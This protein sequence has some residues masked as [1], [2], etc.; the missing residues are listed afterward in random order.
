MWLPAHGAPR[1]LCT[2]WFWRLTKFRAASVCW[3]VTETSYC[4]HDACVALRRLQTG[5]ILLR[6]WWIRELGVGGTLH[7][8]STL[9]WKCDNPMTTDPTQ[10][11]VVN[12]PSIKNW[13]NLKWAD[14]PVSKTCS[15][16]HKTHS[17]SATWLSPGGQRLLRQHSG[18]PHIRLAHS[19]VPTHHTHYY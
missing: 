12:I 10:P 13:L 17:I 5:V 9:V 1:A 14:K 7:E 6:W 15:W 11:E 8:G 3:V 19:G 16:A 18:E 4:A 2:G